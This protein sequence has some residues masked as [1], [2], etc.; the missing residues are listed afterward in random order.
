MTDAST[1]SPYIADVTITITL[2]NGNSSLISQNWSTFFG[3]YPITPDVWPHVV[4]TLTTILPSGPYYCA[5]DS[6]F[7]AAAMVFQTNAS[8]IIEI[9]RWD[10]AQAAGSD[11]IGTA[12][13]PQIHTFAFTPVPD[14]NHYFTTAANGT[15]S[16]AT[17]YFTDETVAAFN[18]PESWEILGFASDLEQVPEPATLFLL[19]SSLA[20]LGLIRRRS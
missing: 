10:A 11:T 15:T 1:I 12:P 2:D 17:Y 3:A 8:G 19:I 5:Y 7:A 18:E 13:S 20:G 9:V 14:P 16:S 6:I 4:V